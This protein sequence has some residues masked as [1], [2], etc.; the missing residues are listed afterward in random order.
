MLKENVANL[1]RATRTAKKLER[2]S[3]KS[4]VAVE[5]DP[6]IYKEAMARTRSD[7]D[8]WFQGILEEINVIANNNTWELVNSPSRRVVRT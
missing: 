4:D 2:C 7:C 8:C 5:E 6:I 3:G 1:R